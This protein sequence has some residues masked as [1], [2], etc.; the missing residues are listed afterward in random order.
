[1]IDTTCDLCGR[2][3]PDDMTLMV[4]MDGRLTVVCFVCDEKADPGLDE[5][6]DDAN[7]D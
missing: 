5:D 3:L 1:M 7:R 6:D 2:H 4:D